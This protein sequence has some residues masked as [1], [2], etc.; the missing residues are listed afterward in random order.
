QTAD[1]G[2]IL[3][4]TS[5]SNISGDKTEACQGYVDFWILKIDSLGNY[6]WDKDFGGNDLEY[7]AIGYQTND[8]GYIIAGYSESGINGN[9]TQANWGGG[10]FWIIKIDSIG[11]YQ[12][13]KDYGGTGHEDIRSFQETTD[14]GYILGGVSSSDSSGDK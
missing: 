13:D 5:A 8:G 2:Y 12:W 4:G 1:G 7:E 3:V 9:K 10:D 11:N 6:Q 14:G